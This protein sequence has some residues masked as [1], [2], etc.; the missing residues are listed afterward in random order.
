M[1]EQSHS[2]NQESGMMQRVIDLTF[3]HKFYDEIL[4]LSRSFEKTKSPQVEFFQLFPFSFVSAPKDTQF[5]RSLLKNT[6]FKKIQTI[7]N[8]K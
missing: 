3:V 6:E 7:I 8:N 2:M 1:A 5:T 4:I